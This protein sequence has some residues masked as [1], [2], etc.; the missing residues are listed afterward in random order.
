MTNYIYL[1]HT[2]T[3]N[4]LIKFFT[5]VSSISNLSSRHM[6]SRDLMMGVSRDLGE[7]GFGYS[8]TTVDS[9]LVP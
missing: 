6:E 3:F 5:K 1:I 7:G 8:L 2:H 4:I 9:L